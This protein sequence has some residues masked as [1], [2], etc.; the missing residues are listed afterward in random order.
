M[1]KRIQIEE[2]EYKIKAAEEKKKNAVILMIVSVFFLWPLMIV[3]AVMHDGACKEIN[4]LNEEKNKILFEE[5][6]IEEIQN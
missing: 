1:D 3:G 6:F 5:Y 2:I 4:R